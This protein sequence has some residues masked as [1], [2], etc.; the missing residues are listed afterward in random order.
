MLTPQHFAEC[1]AHLAKKGLTLRMNGD[2]L[3]IRDVKAE[4]RAER[5]R[6]K[7][8][9]QYFR[10]K[11]AMLQQVAQ[12]SGDE[13]LMQEA[14]IGLNPTEIGLKQAES[15]PRS[16]EIW[17]GITWR[18]V[19]GRDEAARKMRFSLLKRGDWTGYKSCQFLEGD[20]LKA[21][22]AKITE[23]Q[24]A[25]SQKAATLRTEAAHKR[26]QSQQP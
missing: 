24:K 15:R 4:R 22:F 12:F 5:K 14:E 21:A 13:R 26:N 9:D 10:R 18:D 3:E 1:L 2:T 25:K 20:A 16:N 8:R 23:S 7:N 19:P 6:K 11:R 17:R